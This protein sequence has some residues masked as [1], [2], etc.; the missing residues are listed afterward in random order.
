MKLSKKTSFLVAS[1]LFATT[2]FVL[3]QN[4]TTSSSTFNEACYIARYPDV[5]SAWVGR[6]LKAIDH[7]NKYG[8]NENRKPGCDTP[9]TTPVV[10]TPVVTTPA[11][12]TPTTTTTSSSTFNEA[13]YLKR[14]PDVVSGW[15]SKGL[16]A[17]DHYNKHGKAEGRKPG[18]DTSTSTPVVTTP[19]PVVIPTSS[20]VSGA[21]SLPI[22]VTIDNKRFGGAVSSL[23]W[24]GKEFINIY[25]HGRQLQSAMQVDGFAECNNP[26]EAGSEHDA[27]KTTGTSKALSVSVEKNVLK[28]KTQMAYWAFNKTT[29]ACTKG[30]DPRLKNALSD[31]VLEKE[32][33]VGFNNDNQ[34]IKYSVN[35]I[36]PE[37]SIT[38]SV[39]Y[40]FLTGYLNSE[41]NRFYYV[42]TSDKSLNEYLAADLVS[43][44]NNGFPAGSF[45]GAAKN[46]NKFD[47]VIMSTQDGKYA[48]GAYTSKKE[49]NDCKSS[50]HGYNVYKF[51][52]G[53]SGANGNA[54]NKWSMAVGDSV[55]SKCIVNNKRSFVV[56]L[57]I[58]NVDEVHKKLLD[59]A[60]AIP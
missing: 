16:K 21:G 38:E 23:T 27:R 57:A 58:G 42:S 3:F 10:T 56:Y 22:K 15:T 39:V 49:L 13:C 26:T 19:A 45:Y 28:A 48:M 17:I 2:S 35:F 25:D 37:K 50:F 51:N 18:C 20:S 47:P 30:I 29:G 8:K 44:Q 46:K 36:H 60:A 59:L 4:A 6:G 54:T 43:L 24:N 7:W 52:L 53:G 55:T 32:I 11:V 14:Y 31:H 5:K 12:T 1:S 41:F 40:E 33:Q 9:V 34:I